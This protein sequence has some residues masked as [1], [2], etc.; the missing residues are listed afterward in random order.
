MNRIAITAC[1][2]HDNFIMFKTEIK[3]DRDVRDIKKLLSTKKL[4]IEIKEKRKIRSLEANAYF[5]E[6][7]D[8]V[9]AKLL[10]AKEEIYRKIIKDVG[11][12]EVV[13]VRLEALNKWKQAWES[14]GIG[15]FCEA[16]RE[17]RIK[18]Y[19]NVFC[20]FGSSMYDSAEMSRIIDEI[21]RYCEELEIPTRPEEEIKS[22][23]K[24]WRI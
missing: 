7:C 19:V 6:L 12:F 20:Y 2:G 4:C 11:V 24:N 3:A 18:G 17:S 8:K 22:M 5:W 15:W 21:I 23:I 16:D 14:K 13:P 10:S 1:E 9:A